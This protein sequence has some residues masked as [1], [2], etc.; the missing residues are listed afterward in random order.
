MYCLCTKI[1]ILILVIC[2]TNFPLKVL[3]VGEIE[4]DHA[5]LR[6]RNDAAVEGMC[7]LLSYTDG[8]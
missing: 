5:G 7:A 6:L 4:P 8:G 1:I 3:R 2:S